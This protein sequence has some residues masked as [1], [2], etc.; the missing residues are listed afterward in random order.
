M[1]VILDYVREA[2]DGLTDIYRRLGAYPPPTPDEI[3]RDI[4]DV[5]VLLYGLRRN[6]AALSEPH[7]LVFSSRVRENCLVMKAGAD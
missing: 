3:Q 7:P 6:G 2:E 4:A 5:V 1:E